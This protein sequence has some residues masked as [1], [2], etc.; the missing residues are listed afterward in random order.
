MEACPRDCKGSWSD[1]EPNP[2]ACDVQPS[3]SRI[4]SINKPAI[5]NTQY[6]YGRPCEEI[7]DKVETRS[8]QDPIDPCCTQSHNWTGPIG[9]V[10][11][12]RGT[13]KFIQTTEGQCAEDIKSQIKPCCYEAGDWEN[14]GGC[15]MNGKQKQVQTTVG[16]C[17]PGTET[18]Y[19]NCCWMNE[20]DDVGMCNS[21]GEQPQAR[22]VAG[23]CEAVPKEANK[24]L[25]NSELAR[26]KMI[27]TK[28]GVK[29]VRYV[30]FGFDNKTEYLNIGQIEVYSD[31]VN[32]VKNIDDSKVTVNSEYG[33][34]TNY[35]KNQLFDGNNS[36]MYH[37]AG[38]PNDWI[39]IDLG[40]EYM[41][42]EVK[43]FNRTSCSQCKKRW[44]SAVLKLLDS[45][46][47]VLKT[48]EAITD[49][50]T[51]NTYKTYSFAVNPDTLAK[52]EG[53]MDVV[54]ADFT[55]IGDSKWRQII[56]ACEIT[57]TTNEKST[58]RTLPCHYEGSWGQWGP[59]NGSKRYKHRT[60]KNGDLSITGS[61]PST[62]QEQSCGHCKGE[63]RQEYGHKW[64]ARGRKRH[65]RSLYQK[66][67]MTR[68][69]YNGGS[70]GGVP[71][72]GTTRNHTQHRQK[73]GD[74]DWHNHVLETIYGG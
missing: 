44:V 33:D 51:D 35:R 57:G 70:C 37:S 18:R 38:K 60:V 58:S 30:W 64:A 69:A 53:I 59:C 8:R 72:N 27:Q 16:S 28:E 6:G 46:E 25:C 42:D 7:H 11:S 40:K 20:W 54:P 43:V 22:I 19:V 71:S 12:P 26:L 1:W 34:G 47:N 10:C 4:Y 39:K 5:G 23:S 66:F 52:L 9:G 48:G 17:T 13:G 45:S 56:P 24:E 65:H 73:E 63:W 32:I 21:N 50:D 3:E 14:D 49:A 67:H 15:E 2:D 55:T 31:G 36:S 62:Q 74:M 61:S 68:N 41:I 29:G